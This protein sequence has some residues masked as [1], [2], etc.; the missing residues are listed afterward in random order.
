MGYI[1][2]DTMAVGLYLNIPATKSANKIRG[3]INI[4]NLIGFSFFKR[5]LGFMA[6]ILSSKYFI[7]IKQIVGNKIPN[8]NRQYKISEGDV[9]KIGRIWLIVKEI[10]INK[11]EPIDEKIIFYN[12]YNQDLKEESLNFQNN[13]SEITN[14]SCLQLKFKKKG[15]E[16]TPVTTVD[17][18]ALYS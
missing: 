12:S 7:T 8:R 17:N 4:I 11:K 18:T 6:S 10:K 1:L 14:Q 3:L 13:L 5:D 2:F 15:T 16:F 9:L